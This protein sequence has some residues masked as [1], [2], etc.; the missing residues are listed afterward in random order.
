MITYTQARDALVGHINTVMTTQFPGTK[1]FY[2][3][4][5][6]V[7]TNTVGDQFVQVEVSIENSSFVTL[8]A[9]PTDKVSGFIGFRL[10][11][12]EG[13]G[14]RLFLTFAD[15]LN[16]HLR[17]LTLSGVTTFSPVFG[18]KETAEGW[19]AFDIGFPFTFYSTN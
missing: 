7:D 13:K 3:N 2:E 8:E 18:R 5:V 1:V 4:T 17:H 10:Y 19:T 15:T 6:K 16:E 12:K 11:V 9:A 14:S